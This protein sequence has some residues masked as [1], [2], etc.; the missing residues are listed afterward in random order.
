MAF[1]QTDFPPSTAP[2]SA[3]GRVLKRRVVQQAPR[4]SV[5]I[6]RLVLLAIALL[7]VA[8]PGFMT[9]VA[10]ESLALGVLA[11]DFIFLLAVAIWSTVS[12]S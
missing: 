9:F 1:L 3:P 7:A 5:G 8:T 10:T 11:S 2:T 6:A 4:R 12:R